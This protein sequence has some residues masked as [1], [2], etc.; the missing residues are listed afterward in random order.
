MKPMVDIFGTEVSTWLLFQCLGVLSISLGSTFLYHYRQGSWKIYPDIGIGLLLG[1]LYGG[2]IAYV[3]ESGNNL[4]EALNPLKTG[5]LSSG[6]AVA[7]ILV[8][9][10]YARVRK[11][12]IRAMLDAMAPFAALAESLGH[13][14]CFF[15]G[16][17]Y[18]AI[19]ILGSVPLQLVNA[20]FSLVFFM[21]LLPVALKLKVR[22]GLVFL[23]FLALHGGQRFTL[24]FFRH[25]DAVLVMGLRMPQITSLI[26]CLV[27]LMCLGSVWFSRNRRLDRQ[28]R[29]ETW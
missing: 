17:C 3:L 28:R 4:R 26:L 12:P 2:R 14:G 19:P 16:C 24:Q 20:V 13:V 23:L 7:V 6:S 25:D 10:L 15:A 11:M 29:K 18:G 1:S 5:Y 9:F 8:L 22:D 21:L 27:A